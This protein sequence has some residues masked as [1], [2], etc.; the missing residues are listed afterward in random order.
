MQ[1]VISWIA[2]FLMY[3]SPSYL[4]TSACSLA[5][6]FPEQAESKLS[7]FRLRGLKQQGFLCW[8]GP[9][10]E[11]FKRAVAAGAVAETESG[12]FI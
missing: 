1:N 3:R 5:G 7:G 12:G 9:T 2:V 10:C 8:A 6:V 4:N 11:H